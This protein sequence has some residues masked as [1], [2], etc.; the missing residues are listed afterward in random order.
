VIGN[1]FSG[2]KY[3]GFLLGVLIALGYIAVAGFLVAVFGLS[4]WSALPLTAAGLVVIVL[5][6]FSRE[7]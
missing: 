6:F 5:V 2:N 7:K 3:V 1:N 4:L